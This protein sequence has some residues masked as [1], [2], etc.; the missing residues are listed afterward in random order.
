MANPKVA[1]APYTTH[2]RAPHYASAVPA[3]RPTVFPLAADV[4]EKSDVT[5]LPSYYNPTINL[6]KTKPKQMCWRQRLNL[7]TTSYSATSARDS[8]DKVQ[9]I[10]SLTESFRVAKEIYKIGPEGEGQEVWKSYRQFRK[11][12]HAKSRQDTTTLMGDKPQVAPL[13]QLPPVRLAAYPP[14]QPLPAQLKRGDISKSLRLRQDDALR[15]GDRSQYSRYMSVAT[16]LSIQHID[17][18]KPLPPIPQLE[19]APKMRRSMGLESAYLVGIAAAGI[20]HA[21]ERREDI[22]CTQSLRHVSKVRAPRLR[23]LTD[24]HACKANMSSP[25]MA[26]DEGQTANVAAKCGGVCHSTGTVHDAV[27]CDG[28]SLTQ[29]SR[30]EAKLVRRPRP[31]ILEQC[32]KGKQ[33]ARVSTPPMHWR[34]LFDTFAKPA[35][36]SALL[37]GRNRRSSDASFACQGLS[38]STSNSYIQKSDVLNR[39]HARKSMDLYTRTEHMVPEPLFSGNC[40]NSDETRHTRFYQP[41]HDVLSEYQI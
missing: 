25:L 5:M 8:V 26:V 3:P 2:V 18:N 16:D 36:K 32:Q 1:I 9:A 40:G 11:H 41:Y 4:R 21:I 24:K 14:S 10:R 6:P 37:R 34:N 38:N 23:A 7:D 30:A 39:C 13:Q 15:E 28:V 19:P 27:N 17:V 31:L 33:R 20:Q 29:R 22:Q 35:G 12:K